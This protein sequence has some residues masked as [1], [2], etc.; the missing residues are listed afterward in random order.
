MGLDEVTEQEGGAFCSLT[1]MGHFAKTP[2]V[3]S[4]NENA[5]YTPRRITFMLDLGIMQYVRAVRETKIN[6]N[7]DERAS[8]YNIFTR[9]TFVFCVFICGVM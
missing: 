3:G 6:V 5:L 9:P 8:K 7:G 1:A 4:L 2:F